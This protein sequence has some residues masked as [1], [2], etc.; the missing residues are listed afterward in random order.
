MAGMWSGLRHFLDRFKGLSQRFLPLR[1][2][3]YEF[4]HTH[5][6]VHWC[7]TFKAALRSI[8]STTGDEWRRMA[9]QHRRIPL[10]LCY[11]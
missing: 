9:H 1:V 6:H 5:K 7:Q 10:T 2:I 4:L 11:R 8:V 3:R